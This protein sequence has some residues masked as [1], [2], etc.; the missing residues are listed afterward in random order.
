MDAI[1][2]AIRT[3]SNYSVS[4]LN[5]PGLRHFAYKSRPHVQVTM[6]KW[7]DPYDTVGAQRRSVR[8][9]LPLYRGAYDR[10]TRR[11]ITIYQRV[12]DGIHAKGGQEGPLKLQYV[13]TAHECVLGWVSFRRSMGALRPVTELRLL[14]D[15]ST[16]RTVHGAVTK[17]TQDGSCG[18]GEC[19]CAMGKAGGGQVILTRRTCVLEVG[20]HVIS[21]ISDLSCAQLQGFDAICCASHRPFMHVPVAYE[22]MINAK[23]CSVK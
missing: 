12:H 22:V 20:R 11:L 5:I 7:E 10:G 4:E 1:E 3:T 16:V 13:R 19:C 9:L 14:S 8:L 17:A 18:C 6:P 23:V 21:L 15:H 2:R